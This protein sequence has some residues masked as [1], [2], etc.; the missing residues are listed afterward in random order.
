MGK[1]VE[2]RLDLLQRYLIHQQIAMMMPMMKRKQ[3]KAFLLAERCF[4]A[5]MKIQVQL[6][7]QHW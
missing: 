4:S 3:E 5:M 2:E 6:R 7:T 1:N